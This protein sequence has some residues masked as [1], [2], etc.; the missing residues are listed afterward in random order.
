MSGF[1][2]WNRRVE[3]VIAAL[4]FLYARKRHIGFGR[5]RHS[6]THGRVTHDRQYRRTPAG[7]DG[8]G[9]ANFSIMTLP[10]R[11]RNPVEA[12]ADEEGSLEAEHDLTETGRGRRRSY[13]PWAWRVW[14]ANCLPFTSRERRRKRF[15]RRSV[16]S[17]VACLTR[18]GRR[19]G[20]AREVSER[21]VS[22]AQKLA[23][24]PAAE[25]VPHALDTFPLLPVPALA[26]ESSCL[27]SWL[28]FP[29]P[30]TF[31]IRGGEQGKETPTK[32][33]EKAIFPLGKM[34]S[35]NETKG[36]GPWRLRSRI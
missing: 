6:C 2:R 8:L 7:A 14:R 34:V 21:G 23:P 36:R 27:T 25:R 32:R 5:K 3:K 10:T 4:G 30:L 19:V 20:R 35:R 31:R 11:T 9:L 12:G 13:S 22:R 28:V 29:A 1:F 15:I 24:P 33:N 16:G 17:E 26:I 18:V